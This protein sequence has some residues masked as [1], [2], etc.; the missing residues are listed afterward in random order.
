VET[1]PNT[2]VFCVK[3]QDRPRGH[4]HISGKMRQELHSNLT[5]DRSPLEMTPYGIL[6]R[7]PNRFT[8]G[9]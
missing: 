3:A 8:A 9:R 4:G 7:A 5:G 1:A 6:T 2:D